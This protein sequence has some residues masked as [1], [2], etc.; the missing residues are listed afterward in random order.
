MYGLVKDSSHPPKKQGRSHHVVL[1]K[2]PLIVNVQEK[3]M[4]VGFSNTIWYGKNHFI[5]HN[6]IHHC[7]LFTNYCEMFYI[8]KIVLPVLF[9]TSL[10]KQKK[11]Y[12]CCVFSPR[13]ANIFVTCCLEYRV[14]VR[15][16]IFCGTS[17]R[18]HLKV[19]TVTLQSKFSDCLWR[20][21]L[22]A[23]STN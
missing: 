15:S 8:N 13:V 18:R 21:L 11:E 16:N 12:K 2:C 6:L 17:G 22:E 14:V 23:K 1:A 7:W 4:H 3:Q 9:T 5:S 19:L 10:Q 20:P